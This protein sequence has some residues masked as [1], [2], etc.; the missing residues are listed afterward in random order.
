MQQCFAA[1]IAEGADMRVCYE[2][3][4]GNCVTDISN[5]VP[6]VSSFSQHISSACSLPDYSGTCCLEPCHIFMNCC[7]AWNRHIRRRSS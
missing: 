3:C 6:V 1:V 7:P 2:S 4:T 5:L